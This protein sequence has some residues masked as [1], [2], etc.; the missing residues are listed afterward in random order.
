M[1]AQGQALV[2]GGT[3]MLTGCVTRLVADGWAVV[4]PSRRRRTWPAPGATWV[5]GEW[6]RP[7]ELAEHAGAALTGPA[8]LLVAWVHSPHRQPVLRAVGGLLAPRAPVVEVLGSAG[9]DPSV[10]RV[11]PVLDGHPAHRVVLGFRRLSGGGTRWLTNEEIGAGV[12]EAARAALTDRT[13]ESPRVHEVGELR[14]WRD[15]P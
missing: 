5:F 3:G 10:L 4:T 14:P 1:T 13:A 12:Y 11:D 7:A 15:R 8:G 6:S 9:R 2:I